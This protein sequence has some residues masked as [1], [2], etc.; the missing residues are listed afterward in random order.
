MTQFPSTSNPPL[1]ISVRSSFKRPHHVILATGIQREPRI[2]PLLENP[3]AVASFGFDMASLASSMTSNSITERGLSFPNW[4]RLDAASSHEGSHH[5]RT[6]DKHDDITTIVIATHPKDASEAY[7]SGTLR[8]DVSISSRAP[9]IRVAF[10]YVISENA[11]DDRRHDDDDDHDEERGAPPTTAAATSA[12]N[13]PETRYRDDPTDLF[14]PA[15]AGTKAKLASD[16]TT[17][18]KKTKKKKTKIRSAHDDDDEEERRRDR[19]AMRNQ[20]SAANFDSARLPSPPS[21]RRRIGSAPP[22]STTT[23]LS[24]GS[25]R[26]RRGAARAPS[27]RKGDRA[28][29]SVPRDD[30]PAVSDALSLSVAPTP[31]RGRR[32]PPPPPR[33]R[34]RSIEQRGEGRR[35]PPTAEEGP[36]TTPKGRRAS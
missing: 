17:P 30:V 24:R 25:R 28:A 1:P 27:R 29:S 2:L 3:P 8:S 12:D 9:R 35:P 21:H 4:T 14:A 33:R 13:G 16:K 23:P 10:R 34:R 11:A 6:V 15:S 36:P 22:R 19:G 31:R 32:R 5:T 18:K 20:K 26:R 7:R